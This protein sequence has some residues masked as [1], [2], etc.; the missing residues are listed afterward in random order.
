[1]TE[2]QIFFYKSQ[3]FLWQS[4]CLLLMI[5]SHRIFL[6]LFFSGRKGTKPQNQTTCQ[7]KILYID[8]Q[9]DRQIDR[10]RYRLKMSILSEL[11]NMNIEKFSVAAMQSG[12]VT[13]NPFNV[14]SGLDDLY[15]R[16]QIQVVKFG[17]SFQMS[18]LFSIF[19][20]RTL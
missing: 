1:M 8:R 7:H 3:A 13:Y 20:L 16:F 2:N 18:A 5:S 14:S 19:V 4:E 12:N 15:L 9:I 17:D 11:Q 6:F 10:Y